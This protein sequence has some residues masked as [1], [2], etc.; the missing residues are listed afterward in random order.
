[1]TAHH[2]IY[3]GVTCDNGATWQWAPITQN[4]TADQLRPIIPKWDGS[5]LALIWLSGTY[6]SAQTYSLK[7]VGLIKSSNP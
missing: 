1:M 5:H 2:E 4:S 6:S 7:V 3:E